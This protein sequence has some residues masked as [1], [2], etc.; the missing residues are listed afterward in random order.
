MAFLFLSVLLHEFGHCFAGRWME[1]DAQ[2]ILI[3]PLGGLAAVEVPHTPQANFVT[4]AGG[5]LVNL[6]LCGLSALVL[7]IGFK[8]WP[9]LNLLGYPERLDDTGAINLFLLGGDLTK[10]PADGLNL[11]AILAARFF[12][13]NWLQLVLNVVLIGFPFD[14]GRMLQAILWRYSD[15]RQATL[16][17]IFSGFLIMFLL[18]VYAFITQNW[19]GFG[20]AWFTYVACRQ[21]WMLLESGGEEGQFGYDF[22]QGYTS[23][24]RDQSAPVPPPPRRRP[25]WWQRGSSAGPLAVCSATR[26]LAK[27]TNAAWMN[28]WKKCSVLDLPA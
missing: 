3:W 9:P 19:L 26:K 13:V 10:V 23:L 5:P 7:M 11:V 1:G 24:E 16:V 28:C 2:E 14:G 4:A 21:E 8:C 20:L 15:Y 12:W 25:N 17:V 22:S 27:Q 18:G 6:G